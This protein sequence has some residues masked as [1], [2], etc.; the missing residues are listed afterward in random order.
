MKKLIVL[1]LLLFAANA[2]SQKLVDSLLIGKWKTEKVLKKPSNPHYRDII[3]SF[4]ASVFVLNEDHTFE[5]KS[6]QNSQEFAQIR[7][8]S[9]GKTWKFDEATQTVKI[10]DAKD[11]F[12]T[13]R[14]KVKTVDGKTV[15][16]LEE[17]HH[18]LEL[19]MLKYNEKKKEE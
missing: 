1:F 9:K 7:K 2:N 13:M 8:M 4:K 5:L 12:S 6:D 15:F 17:T 19:E 10:G 3:D 14:F 11:N 16:A 18:G